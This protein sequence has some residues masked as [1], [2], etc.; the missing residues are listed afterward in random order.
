VIEILSLALNVRASEP[1]PPTPKA[2]VSAIELLGPV[3]RNRLHGVYYFVSDTGGRPAEGRCNFQGVS[4]GQFKTSVADL[5]SF[6]YVGTASLER[7]KTRQVRFI[8]YLDHR[9][10][11]AYSEV[12]L[13]EFKRKPPKVATI[14]LV[15][16]LSSIC[17]PTIVEKAL[18]LDAFN[19]YPRYGR[20]FWVIYWLEYYTNSDFP[21]AGEPLDAALRACVQDS[22]CEE[23]LRAAYEPLFRPQTSP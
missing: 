15:R 13:Q 17:D 6:R 3:K 14:G 11:F 19:R 8:A 1:M 12:I 5:E 2:E 7:E 22:A 23:L 9:G 16:Q 20:R 21:I 10:I 4:T 18:W